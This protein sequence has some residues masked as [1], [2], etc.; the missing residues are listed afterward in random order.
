MAMEEEG[1][2][3]PEG[4]ASMGT[5]ATGTLYV[6]A[7]PIGNLGDITQRAVEALKA[8]D[9]IA[10]ED[11]RVTRTLLQHLGIS[12]T[13][14]SIREHNESAAAK[15]VIERLARGE[16]VAYVTDA[17]TPAVSDPGARLVD[18]ARTAGHGVVPI[19]G[20]SALTAA[21]SA[22]GLE[23][24]GVVFL[25]FLPVKAGERRLR[26]QEVAALPYLLVAYEAPHRVVESVQAMA[27]VL[28][29][30]DI[31]IARELTKKFE[32]IVRLP[33]A[34]ASAWLEADAN[35]Q[36]GEFVLVLSPAPAVER[37]DSEALRKALA[38]LLAELPVKQA[39][40]MAAK[41]TGARRNDA[42]ALAL[43]LA[44]DKGPA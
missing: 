34:E 4:R 3:V 7:T 5:F 11:T 9:C 14:L 16:R 6:V 38:V 19:P 39:A 36:R 10:A 23:G 25:G 13:L 21:L 37:D 44:K 32:Q 27:E 8:A 12:R 20:A 30:R 22:S 33:L 18:A 35:R 1:G 42:Y 31:V 15:G 26:L 29:G 17:G 43:E 41:L 24:H 2:K 28:G 40:A